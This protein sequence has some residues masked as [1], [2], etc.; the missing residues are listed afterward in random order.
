MLRSIE[1]CRDRRQPAGEFIVNGRQMSGNHKI[2]V[3][4]APVKALEDVGEVLDG[5]RSRGHDTT[6]I[7]L[8]VESGPFA[9]ELQTCYVDDVPN[10]PVLF[11][12]NGARELKR[13]S[14]ASGNHGLQRRLVHFEE[15]VHRDLASR[16]GRQLHDGYCLVIVPFP[17]NEADLS[18][19]NL[20]LR[21]SVG[22]V[23]LHDF[24]LVA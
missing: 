24:E 6:S 11:I 12:R 16:L 2:R 9:D 15:W 14:G 17:S 13:V 18:I 4:L 21:Y 1:P 10:K 23:Q 8:L 19:S 3:A 7:V 22:S 20:L 5:C